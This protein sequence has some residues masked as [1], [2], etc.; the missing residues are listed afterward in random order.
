MLPPPLHR[1]ETLRLTVLRN[2]A[3]LA[4]ASERIYDDFVTIASALAQSPIAL[5][6]LVGQDRQWFKARSGWMCRRR[7]AR[8][9]SAPMPSPAPRMRCWSRMRPWTCDSA[10]IP[11]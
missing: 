3:L 7:R 1:H 5:I 8:S 10:T 9:P 4:R 2:S 11:W 6:S